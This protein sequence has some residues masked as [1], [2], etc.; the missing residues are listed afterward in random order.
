M[1]AMS[2]MSVPANHQRQQR[3]HARRRQGRENRDRMDVALVEH[4][5]HDVD[6][7]PPPRAAGT[8]RSPATTGTLRACPEARR[9]VSGNPISC[10]ARWIAS[11]ASPSERPGARL[12]ENVTD[13]NW[14]SWLIDSGAVPS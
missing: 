5:Q 7:P 6:R 14:P 2:E 10:C 12:N 8:A 9:D 11:T 3:P 4:A 13:G 1:S